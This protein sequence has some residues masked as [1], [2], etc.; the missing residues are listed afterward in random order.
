MRLADRAVSVIVARSESPDAARERLTR[1][2]E[3]PEFART[4]S[5][6]QRFL[7]WLESLFDGGEPSLQAPPS[8][9]GALANLIVWVL[10]V[11]LAVLVI[12]VLVRV[13]RRRVRGN[14]PAT[15]DAEIVL[16]EPDL[17]RGEWESLAARY[18]AAGEWKEAMRC[19][20]RELVARL[21][22]ERSVDPVPGRTTGEL[23]RDVE[24][25]SPAVAA[26]FSE[27]SGLFERPWYADEVTG[28]QENARFRSLAAVVAD[29][30][31]ARIQEFDN[32]SANESVAGLVTVGAIV[33]SGEEVDR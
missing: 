20:Y 8:G 27:A 33:D 12:V 31:R 25:S 2:F 19:R 5:L 24:N 13:I 11:G 28:P 18:E 14:K 1:I 26:A 16:A 4:K 30:A 29:G 3:R 7:E 22:D 17:T 9:L 10:I 21:V 6:W 15:P 32:E 23:R